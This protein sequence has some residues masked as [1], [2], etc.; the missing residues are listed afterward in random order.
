MQNKKII[1]INPIDKLRI[2]M[3]NICRILLKEQGKMKKIFSIILTVAMVASIMSV[4][5]AVKA[6]EVIQISNADELVAF[7]TNTDNA[8]MDAPK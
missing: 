8:N 7:L 4:S 3:Y 6:D 2:G 5:F 1:F